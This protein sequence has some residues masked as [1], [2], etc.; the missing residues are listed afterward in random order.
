MVVQIVELF[1]K[2]LAKNQGDMIAVDP[3]F[4]SINFTILLLAH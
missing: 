2:N 1:A 4:L 3:R